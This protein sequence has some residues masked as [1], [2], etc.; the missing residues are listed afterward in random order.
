MTKQ[1]QPDWVCPPGETIK[2]ILDQHGHTLV[3]LASWLNC[4]PECAEE[5]LRGGVR[6]DKDLARRL[7]DG[8][9]AG[10]VQF[11]LSLDGHYVEDCKRLGKTP[12]LSDA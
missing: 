8:L 6:I 3:D 4:T 10:C 1:F 2:E 12:G 5:L 7:T 11:W 9:R